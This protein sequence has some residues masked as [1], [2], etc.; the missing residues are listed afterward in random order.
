[1]PG[2]VD[3]GTVKIF[4]VALLGNTILSTISDIK[5]DKLELKVPIIVMFQPYFRVVPMHLF[6]MLAFATDSL[7]TLTSAFLLFICLK[8]L[9]DVGMHIVVNKTYRDKRPNA[10]GGWI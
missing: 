2:S 6:I 8:T 10:T 4:L 1:M 5:R 3:V 7:E 9:A